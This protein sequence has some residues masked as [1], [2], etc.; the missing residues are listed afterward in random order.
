[1]SLSLAQLPSQAYH[2]APVS[3]PLWQWGQQG[4]Q[5]PLHTKEEISDP[6]LQE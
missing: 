2:L 1:M 5:E 3:L 4:T 6:P